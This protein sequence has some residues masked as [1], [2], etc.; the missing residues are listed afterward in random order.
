MKLRS[1]FLT[2][3]LS[4]AGVS[5]AGCWLFG[6]GG[7]SGKSVE[8]LKT[9]AAGYIEEAN[10]ALEGNTEKPEC[11]EAVAAV[12]EAQTAVDG[13]NEATTQ[14]DAK[15]VKDQAKEAKEKAEECAGAAQAGADPEQ[16]C[17]EGES[18]VVSCTKEDINHK[19]TL[20]T[21]DKDADGKTGCS[22]VYTFNPWGPT[23]TADSVERC[24]KNAECKV[25]YDEWFAKKANEGFTCN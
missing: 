10:A 16:G 11:A 1:I 25:K 15:G 24:D 14:D 21:Y 20:T 17:V 23:R 7:D 3:F 13:M 2:L 5:L 9:E 12:A 8:E 19:A 4:F 6:D 18:T 22:V